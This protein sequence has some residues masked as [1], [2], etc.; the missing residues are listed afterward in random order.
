[1]RFKLII[2]AVIFQILALFAML[3][4]AFA[5]LYFGKEIRVNVNLYDPR[6]LLRGNYVK[7]QYDFARDLPSIYYEDEH[8]IGMES[9][10]IYVSLKQDENGTYVREGYSFER[11]KEGVFITGFMNYYDITFGIEAF[12]MPRDK[13]IEME[14]NIRNNGAY[15]ILAVMDNGKA[16][17][18]EILPKSKKFNENIN[19]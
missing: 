15:A 9:D 10:K 19:R 3:A 17:V 8:R 11:P 5:P 14:K 7:L 2:S 18:K 6:D 4:N 12:F 1:M 13:A 16:R